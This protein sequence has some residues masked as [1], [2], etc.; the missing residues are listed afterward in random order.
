MEGREGKRKEGEREEGWEGDDGEGPVPP[1]IC[2]G[3]IDASV[4]RPC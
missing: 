3:L 1:N 2:D 4:Q